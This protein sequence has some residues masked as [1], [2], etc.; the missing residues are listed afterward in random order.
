M[1]RIALLFVSVIALMVG[2]STAAPAQRV[3]RGQ[4]VFP[5]DTVA[6]PRFPGKISVAEMARLKLH[7]MTL[8]RPVTML[9][10]HRSLNRF[11]LERLPAGTLVLADSAG[12]PRY[13]ADCVNRL[14]VVSCPFCQRAV[15]ITLFQPEIGKGAALFEQ[16]Y[17]DTSATLLQ[18]GHVGGFLDSFKNA[19][20]KVSD[21]TGS[22]LGGLAGVLPWLL[23]LLLII[24][25]VYLLARALQ[26]TF[27]GGRASGAPAPNAVATATSGTAVPATGVNPPRPIVS[28]AAAQP[29]TPQVA[30]LP[31]AVPVA[32]PVSV[33]SEEPATLEVA[34]ASPEGG[35]SATTVA[36]RRIR[37]RRDAS[38]AIT[39]HVP[40][41]VHDVSIVI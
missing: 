14:A 10:E 17:V 26:S 29:A 7:P 28:Q 32:T 1:K 13:K 40:E 3:V 38:G 39:L 34:P 6:W 9:N 30:T 33:I 35:A 5:L 20:H 8:E 27:G 25:L 2:M 15:N 21:A 23:A 36:E 31:V 4:A 24:G 37:F 16:V 11:V 22:F 19:F 12:V 41:G 18:T